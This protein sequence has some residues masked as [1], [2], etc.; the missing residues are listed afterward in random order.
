MKRRR[1][2]DEVMIVNPGP[3]GPGNHAGERA[4][5]LG[6]YGYGHPYGYAAA[7]APGYY[8]GPADAYYGA[9]PQYAGYYAGP[10]A[11]YGEYEPV[12]YYAQEMPLGEYGEDPYAIGAYG[13]IPPGYAEMPEMVGYGDPYA[14]ADVYGEGEDFADDFAQEYAGYADDDMGGY[15][16]ETP[17]TFNAGCPMPTNTGMGVAGM[18]A[19]EPLEGYVRPGE[20]SPACQQFTPQP[21]SQS[22]VPETFRPLW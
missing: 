8:A 2:F 3:G 20:V 22:S 5:R 21:A 4:M 12:G 18:G 16:R 1:D 14:E 17:P 15:V 9:A 13:P 7:P 11:G 19:A 6:Y 10:A